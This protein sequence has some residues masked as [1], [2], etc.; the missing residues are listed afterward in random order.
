M[1]AISLDGTWEFRFSGETAWLPIPVPGCWE[2]LGVPK[3]RPGPACY[4]TR[5]SVPADFTNRRIWL[6][7]DAVS[8]DCRVLVN[9][10]EV[11]RHRGLW[12]AFVV[13]ITAAAKAGAEAELLL[14]VEKPATLRLGPA[15]E[16]LPGR[17]PLKQT[18]SGF[19]PYVW[20]NIFGGVWQSVYLFSTGSASIADVYIRGDAGGV[21]RVEIEL[22]APRALRVDMH[23]SSGATV[24]TAGWTPSGADRHCSISL[25]LNIPQPLPWSPHSPVLYEAR[26]TL[27]DGDQCAVRFGLRTLAADQTRLLLNA[28]PIYPR[29]ALSW[30]WYAGSLHSN[31]GPERVRADFEQ[32]RALGYNG[33]KLCLWFPPR[34]YFDLADELGMLLWVE[35]PMWLPEP[36]PFWREQT[37]TEYRRLVRHARN[38]PSVILYSLGCELGRQV[39]AEVLQPLYAAVKE[40]AGDA[41]VRDNSGSGEAYGGL[42]NEYADYYDYHFYSEPQFFRPLLDHFTPRWRPLKPWVFGE[43]CDLDTFRDLQRVGRRSTAG[44]SGAGT[45]Q[46]RTFSEHDRTGAFTDTTAAGIDTSATMEPGRSTTDQEREPPWWTLDDPDLNPQGARWQYDVVHQDQRLRE[47]GFAE[48][49]AELEHISERQALLHR[50]WTLET[51]RLYNEIGG[52]VVTG[53]VDTPISTAGMWDDRGRL[54]F[55]PPAF[56]AFNDDLVL[57]AGWDRR[58]A[59][60]AGG[61]RAAYWDP[62]CYSGATM[63]RAHLI[64]SHYGVAAGSGVVEWSVALEGEPPFAAGSAAASI[65]PG[66][67]REI[68]VAEFV[69]PAGIA[70]RPAVLRAELRTASH[71]A[72]NEWPLWFFPPEPWRGTNRLGLVDPSGRLA[73]LRRLV[74]GIDGL[75]KAR[76]AVA[77]AWTPELSGWVEHGGRAV[78]LLAGMQDNAPVRLAE[79]PFWREAVRVVEQHPA[80]GDFPHGGFAGL[81]FFGCAADHA[82]DIAPLGGAATQILSRLD[83]R[84]MVVHAYAAELRYGDGRLIVST[85]RIEGGQG[86]QPLGVERNLGA[87]YLLRCWVR[88]LDEN[89]PRSHPKH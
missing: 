86:D 15:S 3:N 31:P 76:V 53:E 29:L 43:F 16:A 89:D 26:I 14:E 55:D 44:S 85:L 67:V 70:P 46:G 81:Q 13:E 80:W 74:P 7:F 54:K 75:D 87:S 41:L 20:G 77:T 72:A 30:G 84:T 62:S 12:D 2:A 33:V 23:D 8:Y 40:L 60:V 21:V 66:D 36:T 68:T 73:D 52:Y 19:L 63:V 59:W 69:A 10:A 42:L 1:Q 34:Y 28:R 6:R 79:M 9:G 58:R 22:T 71:H 39:G 50:K 83:A 49:A 37:P 48:R 51:V 32:L 57:L 65:A 17:F 35:L 64:A 61:D 78:L 45:Y 25:A 82:I 88:Y 4:R 56:R 24:A 11:G 27:E 47:N 38:H 5:F 18:L